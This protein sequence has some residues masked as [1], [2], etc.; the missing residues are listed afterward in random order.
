MWRALLAVS[1]ASISSS[2]LKI[3]G[4]LS[5]TV[6]MGLN[7]FPG[8]A[9]TH[10]VNRV[11]SSVPVVQQRAHDSA[12]GAMTGLEIGARPSWSNQNKVQ[13]VPWWTNT[14]TCWEPSCV[15]EEAKPG[16]QQVFL[17]GRAVIKAPQ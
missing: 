14:G 8:L 15:H 3:P 16:I 1:P 4:I 6:W 11:P 2:C 10:L 17:E 12:Q 7:P 5:R 9:P 13:L